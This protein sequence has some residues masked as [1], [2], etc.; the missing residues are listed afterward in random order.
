MCRSVDRGYTIGMTN[1]EKKL[2]KNV[3]GVTLEVIGF[4]IVE[5]DSEIEV[6]L[7]FNNS[8][9]AEVKATATSKPKQDKKE[10]E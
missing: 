9:F 6:P 2:V 4:G 8:N 1:G 3:S 5:A 7:D 10:T